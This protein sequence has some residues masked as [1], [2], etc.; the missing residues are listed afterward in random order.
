MKHTI[1]NY[2]FLFLIAFVAVAC[3]NGNGT[4]TFEADA[5]N[6]RTPSEKIEQ[7][8]QAPVSA[9]ECGKI[10]AADSNWN[11][12]LM[13]AIR[14]GD[15]GCV[16]HVVE[17]G[18]VDVNAPHAAIGHAESQ[19]PVWQALTTS[20]L[21]F[22]RG[23]D[24]QRSFRVLKAL[25]DAGAN[26]EIKNNQNQSVLEYTLEN[27]EVFERYPNVS[28]FLI[29]SGKVKLNEKNANGDL[30]IHTAIFRKSFDHLKLLVEKGA[31]F[32]ALSTSGKTPL[33]LA[34][35]INFLFGAD[36]LLSHGATP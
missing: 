3:S 36:F 17:N 25:A 6:P 26:F 10:Y 12:E 35:E 4:N 28:A 2:Q 29:V 23:D 24:D 13:T 5:G 19:L 32:N 18:K 11:E 31:D 8:A 16:Q 33:T 9:G 15:A 30:P 7:L 21:F 34:R 27:D 20:A 1:L 22:A 14:E